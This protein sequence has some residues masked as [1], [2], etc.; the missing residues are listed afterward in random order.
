M[1]QKSSN[2]QCSLPSILSNIK[3][4][5]ILPFLYVG[6]QEDALSI[7]TMQVSYLFGIFIGFDLL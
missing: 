7:K 4:S 5:Q 1:S 3:P 6:C 2:K